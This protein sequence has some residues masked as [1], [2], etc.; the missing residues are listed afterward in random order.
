MRGTETDESPIAEHEARQIERANSSTRRPVVFIHGL[1]LLPCC[2]ERWVSAF[3][4]DGYLPLTPG[5]PDDPQTVVEAREH[6]EVFAGKSVSHIVAHLEGVICRL[7]KKPVL[8]GHSFGGLLTQIIAGHG[9][10]EVSVAI[11]PAPFRGVF[12]IPISLLHSVLPVLRNP[13]NR[14]RA[15]SLTYPQF[16]YAV[17][18]TTSEREA[19]ALYQTHGVPAGG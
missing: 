3:E 2:W 14:H 16:R 18:N 17:A 9:L 5:W 7:E 8:I 15:V 19:A 10:A 6:P 13:A 12:P 1:W 4:A 11:S